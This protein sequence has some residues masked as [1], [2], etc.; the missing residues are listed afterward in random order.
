[1]RYEGLKHIACR[2]AWMNDSNATDQH[3]FADCDLYMYYILLCT[4]LSVAIYR[5]RQVLRDRTSCSAS[6]IC[7]VPS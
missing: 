2:D 1:M 6:I 3:G 4:C 7:K 5:K